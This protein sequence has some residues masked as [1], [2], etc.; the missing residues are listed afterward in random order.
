MPV[1][2]DVSASGAY[3]RPA[4]TANPVAAPAGGTGAT[5]GAYDTAANRNIAIATINS[6][7]TR[8]AEIEAVLQAAGLLA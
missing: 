2:T 8:V 1:R 7:R 4:L 6:L 3:P 5:A